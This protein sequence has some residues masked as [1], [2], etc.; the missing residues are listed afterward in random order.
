MK[1]LSFTA[2]AGRMYCGSCLHDN[3]LAAELKRQG[4]DVILQAL[5]TPTRT[6]EANV[7][8][9]RVFFGGISVY[10]EER[11][12]VFRR[13]PGF[14]DALWDRPS[15]IARFAG[16]GVEVDPKV[17]GELTVSILRGAHGHQHKEIG[18]LVDWLRHEPPPDVVTLPFTLLISL[19]EPLKRATGRPVVCALQGEELF[20]SSLQEPWRGE[21]LELIRGQAR[22]VDAFI[23]VSEYA[24]NYMSG[25]LGIPRERIRVVPL[26]IPLDG[27]APRAGRPDESHRIGYLARIAPEKGLR[28]LCEAYRFLRRERGLP[29][30]R[31]VAAGYLPPENK[32]YLAEI[33]ARMKEW[34]YEREFQYHGELDR[35][36]KIA[37]LRSLDV[38]SCPCTYDEPK[39]LPV[40]E[41]MANG[42]P[43]VQPRRGSFPEMLEE[44]RGGLLV[45][46]DSAEALAAGIERVLG[47]GELA[48]NLSRQ[49]YEDVHA[50][51]GIAQ[52]ARRT[53]AAYEAVL[54][55][56][57]PSPR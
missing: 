48:A 22:H 10:L 32:E 28:L 1:I 36:N 21:A 53:I 16:R 44:C 25:Y 43:V 5:Y 29:P 41:A 35:A 52:E 46:P 14:L 15:V 40:L 45:D 34:G 38:F 30:S 11:F 57:S 54:A 49:G 20:L 31:L 51:R 56:A 19:A 7:S 3:S 8:Q 9:R 27:H 12:S 4:H 18:K 37:M 42:V 33:S 50:R 2:G 47:D 55:A 17:L 39:G 26:G 6:D 13:L 23:A 24:A